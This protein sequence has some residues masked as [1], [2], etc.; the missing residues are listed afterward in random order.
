M[1]AIQA[2]EISV[3]KY[4]ESIKTNAV[5]F[6]GNTAKLVLHFSICVSTPYVAVYMRFECL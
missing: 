3:S 5:S 2:C 1:K 6:Q 4:V